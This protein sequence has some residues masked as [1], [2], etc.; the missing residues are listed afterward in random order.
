MGEYEEYEKQCRIIR[1]ENKVLLGEFSRFLKAKGLKSK[2]VDNHR[3]N[4]SFYINEFLLYSDVI[5]AVDGATHINM[6]LSY[7]FIKKAMWASP[8]AIKSNAASLKKF[9]GFLFEKNSISK[10]SFDELKRNIKEEMP[11][12]IATMNRYDDP[13][14]DDMEDVWRF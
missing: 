11:D 8:E 9:Y 2:T 1:K 4:I 13:S 10:E 14:I 6:Y 12:W 3:D 7:W 5:R